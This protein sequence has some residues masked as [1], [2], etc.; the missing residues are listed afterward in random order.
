MYTIR[1]LKNN[2]SFKNSIIGVMLFTSGVN[3]DTLFGIYFD[4]EKTH[5]VNFNMP[6]L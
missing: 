4:G 2:T 5:G 3:F 1:V 6:D